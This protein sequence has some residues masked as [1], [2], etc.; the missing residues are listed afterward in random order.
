[1]VNNPWQQ[2]DSD[3]VLFIL[4]TNHNVEEKLLNEW[5]DD[6]Q[7]SASYEGIVHRVNVPIAHD[8]ET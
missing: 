1:M 4:D 7:R 5:L 8:P 3:S 6:S 2:I